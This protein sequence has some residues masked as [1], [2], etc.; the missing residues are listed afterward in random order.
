MSLP[1][2]QASCHPEKQHYAL[3]YCL[4]CYQKLPRIKNRVTRY[5][6]SQKGIQKRRNSHLKITH[7]MTEQEY[8]TQL[9]SQHGV[10]AICGQREMKFRNRNLSVDHNHNTHIC[11]SLLCSFC[12]I[13]LGA[14]RDD[15]ELLVNAASYLY[16]WH[17][18]GG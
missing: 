4:P 17:T 6:K 14:F 18:K 8:Q 3:G 9:Q 5:G 11:R 7:N 10:C 15:P 13:G 12:N 2:K 16:F 1:K